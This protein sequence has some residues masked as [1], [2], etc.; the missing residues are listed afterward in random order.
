M[1]NI[2]GNT[3][4]SILRSVKGSILCEV[5][6]V[7]LLP[8]GVCYYPNREVLYQCMH[9]KKLYSKEGTFPK[10]T[11]F[12][13]KLL[14]Y[15][16]HCALGYFW[17]W[18]LIL[19]VL[20][21]ALKQNSCSSKLQQYKQ[22][23]CERWMFACTWKKAVAKLRMIICRGNFIR[24]ALEKWFPLQDK[25]AHSLYILLHI[26]IVLINFIKDNAKWYN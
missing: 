1:C 14:C 2:C 9:N 6:G 3:V 22:T 15:E 16:Y 7:R 20:L 8:R 5:H 17:F 19:C 4:T 10:Q 13:D 25:R 24:V 11:L 23:P 21:S 26:W 18:K 12:Q